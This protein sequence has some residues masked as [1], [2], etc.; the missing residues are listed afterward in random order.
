MNNPKDKVNRFEDFVEKY[1]ITEDNCDMKS[2]VDMLN[3]LAQQI[4]ELKN[5]L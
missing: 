3:Y 5:E 1:P 2:I 4:E